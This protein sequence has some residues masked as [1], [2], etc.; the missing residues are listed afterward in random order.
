MNNFY[1]QFCYM[2][3]HVCDIPWI[4]L[5]YSPSE[6]CTTNKVCTHSVDVT[7]S[8]GLSLVY[9]I[10]LIITTG[11]CNYSVGDITIITLHIKLAK[12][13]EA[14]IKDTIYVLLHVHTHTEPC[15]KISECYSEY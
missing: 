13:N 15:E 12:I 1:C 8:C 7:W 2:C 10:I 3:T 5:F 6:Y 14:T 9:N 11:N 4:I